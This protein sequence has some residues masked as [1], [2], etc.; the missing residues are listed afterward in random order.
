MLADSLQRSDVP[1]RAF[2]NLPQAAPHCLRPLGTAKS[3]TSK[4]SATLTNLG[5]YELS[6]YMLYNFHDTPSDLYARMNLNV[7]LNEQLGIR[8][9]S[10]PMRYQPTDLRQVAH[11]R[12]VDTIP[13]ASMQIIL[14]AT[15]GVVSGAPSSS[16]VHSAKDEA[17]F[18]DLLLWPHKF[19]FNRDWYEKSGGQ[20]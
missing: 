15:H 13:V 12:K 18:H 17:A 5:L 8:I 1:A 14:Q 9:W 3:L 6:N 10:F 16:N 4:R 19:I 11:R 7:E 20:G 2:H